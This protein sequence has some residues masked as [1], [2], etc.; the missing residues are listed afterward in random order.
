MDIKEPRS[1]SDSDGRKAP[2]VQFITSERM[3]LK[4]AISLDV[5]CLVSQAPVWS[6]LAIG[7]VKDG[8]PKA[9]YTITLDDR[10]QQ[11]PI[12][13]QMTDLERGFTICIEDALARLFT[14][15]RSDVLQP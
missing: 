5:Y 9:S 15:F 7:T 10:G 2:N 1:K 6:G 12:S 13:R 4:T 11:A 8:S 14:T 3:S